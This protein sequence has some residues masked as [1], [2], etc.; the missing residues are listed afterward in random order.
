MIITIYT[1]NSLPILSQAITQ[2]LYIGMVLTTQHE[3]RS[4]MNYYKCTL[5]LV[6]MQEWLQYISDILAH[7]QETIDLLERVC[8]FDFKFDTIL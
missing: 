4:T 1:Q 3:R 6:N 2:Y 7:N 5:K 8:D